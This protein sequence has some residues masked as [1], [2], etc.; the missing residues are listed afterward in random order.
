MRWGLVGTRGL[1]DRGGLNAF[2]EAE[3]A[4][5]VAVLSSDPN[6]ASEFGSEHGVETATAEIDEFLAA[7]GLE[8]VWIASPTWRHHEQGKAAIEASKHVLLEK[9]LAIDVRA[10]WDLVETA[11][12]AGVLLATGYQGRYVPG[13]RNMKRLIADGAIG[14]VTVARTYY[15]IHRPGPPPEWRQQR[16]TARW[17]ALSDVGTHHIDLLRMLLGEISEA[18]GYDERQQGFET[19]DAVA[20]ALRLESGA[21]ATLTI[22]TNV[23]IQFTRVEVHGTQGVLV[24][25]N[26]NPIGQGNVVLLREG[27]VP[28]DVTGERPNAWVAELEE[29]TRAASGEDVP[30]A[31]GEDGARALE[32][33][34]QIVE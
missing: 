6:R 15:G 19:D 23:W 13:H 33:M 24:A 17:G 26:T 16:E 22:S 1:V 3:N 28:E 9:P 27:A 21:V 34:E 12:Q 32:V 10:G 2:R 25:E 8:A 5:L 18:V 4:E 7:P 31:T 29:V 30:Y 14:D 20:A 11:K